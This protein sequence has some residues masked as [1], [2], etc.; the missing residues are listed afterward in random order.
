M[1]TVLE[2]AECLRQ[3]ALALLIQER[4]AINLKIAQLG[5]ESEVKKD[6]KKSSCGKCG[7]EGHTSRTCPSPSETTG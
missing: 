4:E 3:Q 5:G 2:E 7:A 1:N 6:R